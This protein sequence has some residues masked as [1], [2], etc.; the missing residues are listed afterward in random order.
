M[1][2]RGEISGPRHIWTCNALPMRSAFSLTRHANRAPVLAVTFLDSVKEQI[3]LVRGGDKRHP[4][5]P[6]FAQQLQTDLAKALLGFF[7]A[8]CLLADQKEQDYGSINLT[9]FGLEGIV[10]RMFD[11]VCRLRNL[12]KRPPAVKSETILDTIADSIDY[13]AI[14]FLMEAGLWPHEVPSATNTPWHP[15]AYPPSHAEVCG[16]CSRQIAVAG[17]ENSPSEAEGSVGLRPASSAPR[18]ITLTD[19]NGR[20]LCAF[21]QSLIDMTRNACLDSARARD[22]ERIPELGARYVMS[23]RV[24]GVIQVV[25]VFPSYCYQT[26]EV[27]IAYI[28]VVEAQTTPIQTFPHMRVEPLEWFCEHYKQENT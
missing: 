3:A 15:L 7:R 22:R 27:F 14:G 1:T 4:V 28:D 26:T 20:T 17:P 23:K 6:T 24:P 10:I 16:Q 13:E 11:K 25:M 8:L 5:K 2:G 12:V 21:D 9:T 18:Q 19:P